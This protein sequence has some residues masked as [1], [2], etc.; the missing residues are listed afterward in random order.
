M[1]RKTAI[2]VLLAA[3]CTCAAC[4]T[5]TKSGLPDH[6]RTVDVEI[7]RNTTM[8]KSIEGILA[9]SIADAV[10]ADPRVRLSTSGSADAVITG[11][12]TT[13]TR[14]TLRDTTANE[15]GTVRIVITAKYSFYDTQAKRYLIRD[16]VVSSTSTG[17]SHGI[18]EASRG[19]L[20]AQGER[21]AAEAIG[22]EIARQT[23]GMW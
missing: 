7:F 4:R 1:I 16:K 2:A 22:A 20:S 13:V 6:I 18:Y 9:R 12:I 5:T 17:Y 8:Y 11:E 15:P 10:S 19:E 21:G 23:I 14:S 3:L